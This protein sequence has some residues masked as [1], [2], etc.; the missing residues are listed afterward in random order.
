MHTSARLRRH[1]RCRGGATENSSAG[2]RG[3]P[4]QTCAP[5]PPCV[6]SA[7]CAAARPAFALPALLLRASSALSPASTIGCRALLRTPGSVAYGVRWKMWS[8]EQHQ[9]FPLG[10]RSAVTT[11]LMAS[12]RPDVMT[13]LRLEPRPFC[14]RTPG[15]EPSTRTPFRHRQPT[16]HT[17]ALHTMSHMPR[18]AIARPAGQRVVLRRYAVK[19]TLPCGRAR[20]HGEANIHPHRSLHCTP[21]RTRRAARSRA[22]RG[23]W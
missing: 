9:R 8:P 19:I 5:S 3:V 2:M 18:C 22:P 7:A 17:Y 6:T 10:F 14:A 20:A 1:L 4:S 13:A 15:A 12:R 21:C 16:T 23:S 11:M